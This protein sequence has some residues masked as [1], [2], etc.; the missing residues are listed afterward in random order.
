MPRKHAVSEE[1]RKPP[2]FRRGFYMNPDNQ[3]WNHSTLYSYSY[4]ERMNKLVQSFDH[5]NR[6]MLDLIK[7]EMNYQDFLESKQHSIGNFG[8]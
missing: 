6:L 3:F 8:I 5:V 1:T 4:S 2:Y 7:T